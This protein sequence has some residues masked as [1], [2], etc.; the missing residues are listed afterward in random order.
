MALV[1][2][3]SKIESTVTQI[4]EDIASP[5]CE[6]EANL[7]RHRQNLATENGGDNRGRI[8]RCRNPEGTLLRPWIECRTRNESV[9]FWQHDLKFLEHAFPLRRWFIALC[10]SHQQIIV[11]RIPHS[12]QGAAHCRLA[13]QQPLGGTGYVEFHG[14]H[15]EHNQEIQVGL[16][17]L[18]YTHNEY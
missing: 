13:Q 2:N 7:S 10:R 9:Q 12:L 11:K 8:V 18:R 16:T 14:K 15:R 6:R 3:Q 1:A 4:L 5:T 17:Q